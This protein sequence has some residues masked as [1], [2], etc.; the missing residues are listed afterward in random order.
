MAFRQII[1]NNKLTIRNF[2]TFINRT[3]VAYRDFLGQNLVKLEPGLRINLPMV[4]NLYR[5]SLKEISS[6]FLFKK[7]HTKDDIPVTC[8]G[9]VFFKVIDPKKVCFSLQNP[10]DIVQ[11]VGESS[12]RVVIGRFDCNEI[13]T[14]RNKINS[15]ILKILGKTTLRL[16]INTTRLE[17]DNFGPQKKENH[18]RRVDELQNQ[19]VIWR[20]FY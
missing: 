16:G 20:N 11:N 4:H 5:V 17:I 18:Y 14:N 19:Y 9:T 13:Q 6:P 10:V 8:S 3:E 15:V 2:I 1:K 12:F 7:A